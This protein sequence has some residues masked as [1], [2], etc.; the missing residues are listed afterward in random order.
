MAVAEASYLMS[1]KTAGETRLVLKQTFLT[2]WQNG[3]LPHEL[4]SDLDDM[5]ESAVAALI[6]CD[7]ANDL[8]L[9]EGPLD[10]IFHTLKDCV[11]EDAGID[12]TSDDKAVEIYEALIDA[13]H[14]PGISAQR[15][16]S[17]GLDRFNLDEL[18]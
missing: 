2:M 16:T 6:L 13:C 9:A 11:I 12:T 8:D 18:D 10:V 4:L 7:R 15:R 3:D 14:L 1:A 5:A 17:D